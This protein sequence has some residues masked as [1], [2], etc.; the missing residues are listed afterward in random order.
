VADHREWITGKAT[1][2]ATCVYAGTAP[3]LLAASDA[4]RISALVQPA[5]AGLIGA[6]ASFSASVGRICSVPSGG[7]FEEANYRGA[8][9]GRTNGATVPFHVWV[10]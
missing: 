8:L 2:L 9:Y 7:V 4:G 6:N 10:V 1:G 3:Q 5:D